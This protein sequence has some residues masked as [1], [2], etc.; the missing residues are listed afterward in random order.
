MTYSEYIKSV[1][2]KNIGFLGIGRS[3][4]PLIRMLCAEGISVTVRDGKKT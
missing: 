3:N 4:M 2:D 1:K